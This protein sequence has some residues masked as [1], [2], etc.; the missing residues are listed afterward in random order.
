MCAWLHTQ[1]ALLWWNA[2]VWHNSTFIDGDAVDEHYNV[3]T[4]WKNRSHLFF[5]LEVLSQY[6]TT[7]W[8]IFF[9][10]LIHMGGT[11]FN[12][13]WYWADCSSIFIFRKVHACMH[14]WTSQ[15]SVTPNKVKL[16]SSVNLQWYAI[17][18]IVPQTYQYTYKMAGNCFIQNFIQY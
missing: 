18:L 3:R 16:V 4:Q 6:E 13:T 12:S 9:C 11:F 17:K 1:I 5:N 8:H 10:V 7:Y 15:K 14:T 2:T